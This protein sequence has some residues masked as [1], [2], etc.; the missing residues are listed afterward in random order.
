VLINCV[1]YENGRKLAEIPPSEIHNYLTRPECFVWV[2]LKDPDDAELEAM[3]RQF[4]LH[5]LAV[6]D[7]RHGHQR[8][9]IE[10]YG[11]S[12]FV[13]MHM[14]ESGGDELHV[15]EL[16]VFIGS[17]Y[18]LSVRSRAE[19]GFKDVRKRAKMSPSYCA[20]APGMSCTR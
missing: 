11:Q 19:Q 4:G 14:I 10:E 12:L 9:K 20:T 17:H 16:G 8:P 13:V 15:G 1:A 3:Q 6:E 18:V 2:G 5:P 7:A